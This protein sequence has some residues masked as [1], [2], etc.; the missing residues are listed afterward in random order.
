MKRGWRTILAILLLLAA[1]VALAG[2]SGESTNYGAKQNRGMLANLPRYSGAGKI[3]KQGAVNYAL[4]CE[5]TYNG[6]ARADYEQYCDAFRQNFDIDFELPEQL[7]FQNSEISGF[8]SYDE[9]A[10]TMRVAA[11]NKAAAALGELG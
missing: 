3:E 5:V 4:V 2:C 7:G 10:K 11:F 8:L 9:A 1:L 6:V